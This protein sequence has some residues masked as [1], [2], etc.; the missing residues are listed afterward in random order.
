MNDFVEN[1]VLS[2][3][4]AF[5]KRKMDVNKDGVGDYIEVLGGKYSLK[6]IV[7]RDGLNNKTLW[8]NNIL[9]DDGFNNCQYSEFKNIAISEN[10]FTLEYNTCADNSMLGHRYTTFRVDSKN[11]PVVIQDNYLVNELNGKDNKKP[12]KIN[13][14]SNSKVFFSTYRGRCG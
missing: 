14:M 4:G 12:K 10:N 5:L 2:Y 9:F 8:K 3:S 13:C 6:S 11:E 1:R 7:I